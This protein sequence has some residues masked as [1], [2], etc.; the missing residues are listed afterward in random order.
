MNEMAQIEMGVIEEFLQSLPEKVFHLGIRVVLAA[1]VLLMGIQ[2]I[3][4]V[5]TIIRKTLTKSKVDESAVKFLDSFVKYALYFLLIILTASW[6]GVDAA[7]ILALLGSAS[8]ALGLALQGSL[9][10]MAGGVLILIL[11]PFALGD[12]IRDEKGNEGTVK[13]IDVF[14]THIT[15][16]DNKVVVLPNGTLVNGCITNYTKC[17]MRRIDIPVG[18]AY[19][20]DIRE[21]KK[22][23]ETMLFA[24]KSALADQERRVFVDSLGDSA[25]M[26]N[27]R[28]WVKTSEYWEV[29]WRMTEATKYALDDAGIQI[30]YPQMDV[31]IQSK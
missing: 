26:L 12:Y 15:T 4:I 24:E 29:K 20:E 11:K 3:K 10:N 25:V 9:S 7:S 30:P 8:V 23:L 14:Y 17:D 2:L 18:I 1:L 5:R 28:C 31:H 19:D 27:I 21:A 22:V 16:F 13:A 6:L